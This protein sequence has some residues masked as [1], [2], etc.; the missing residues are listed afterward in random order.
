MSRDVPDFLKQVR[1]QARRERIL[2]VLGGIMEYIMQEHFYRFLLG[3][4]KRLYETSDK[5]LKTDEGRD[6]A[7][8]LDALI[9]GL[10]VKDD[11]NT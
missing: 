9:E 3:L 1:T 6:L 8:K 11:N 2:H 10:E 7:I 5:P 4:K